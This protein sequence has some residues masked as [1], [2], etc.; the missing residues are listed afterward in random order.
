MEKILNDIAQSITESNFIGYQPI[1]NNQIFSFIVDFQTLR[2][3]NYWHQDGD[4]SVFIGLVYLPN[5]KISSTAKV[6]KQQVTLVIPQ[7]GY[8][9]QQQWIH[10]PLMIT[11]QMQDCLR[12]IKILNKDFYSNEIVF[13]NNI[14]NYHAT[15]NKTNNYL[16]RFKIKYTKL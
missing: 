2:T 5:R 1:K 13:I 7:Q 12:D 10:S 3:T 14:T 16:L 9:S 8:T 15:P 4:G 6:P 11:P